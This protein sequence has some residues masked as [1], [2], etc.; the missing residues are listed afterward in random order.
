M[1]DQAFI[2]GFQE[3]IKTY[4]FIHGFVEKCSESEIAP[5]VVSAAVVED[6]AAPAFEEESPRPTC[7]RELAPS[8]VRLFGIRNHSPPP[9]YSL[10]DQQRYA[11]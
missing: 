3:A 9:F 10:S 4:G 5:S 6:A 11:A 8:G 7:G 2:E 1:L